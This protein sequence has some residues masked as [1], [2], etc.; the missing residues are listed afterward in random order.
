MFHKPGVCVCTVLSK[1]RTCGTANSTSNPAALRG[2]RESNKYSVFSKILHLIE[3][4]PRQTRSLNTFPRIVLYSSSTFVACSVLQH[5]SGSSINAHDDQYYIPPSGRQGRSDNIHVQ[6]VVNSSRLRLTHP[7]HNTTA[8]C[9]REIWPVRAE[10]R[11]SLYQLQLCVEHLS[12]FNVVRY[13]YKLS[14][15]IATRH[16]HAAKSAQCS[17]SSPCINSRLL[18]SACRYGLANFAEGR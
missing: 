17:G 1:S 18:L 15:C 3:Y 4:S 16:P 11:L 8:T 14:S 10:A 9:V 12:M 2:Y 13:A 5:E 7:V 6:R